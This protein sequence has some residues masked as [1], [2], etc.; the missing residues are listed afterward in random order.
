MVAVIGVVRLQGASTVLIMTTFC[1]SPAGAA[2]VHHLG[3]SEGLRWILHAHPEMNGVRFSLWGV[4]P[5]TPSPIEALSEAV[6]RGGMPAR[7]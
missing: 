7:R 2:T 5:E 1:R 6:E 3:L 4:E